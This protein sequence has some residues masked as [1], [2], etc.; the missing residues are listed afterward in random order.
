[1]NTLSAKL[2][3]PARPRPF[4]VGFGFWMALLLGMGLAQAQTLSL[5][6]ALA[7]AKDQ[8]TVASAAVELGDAKAALSRTLSDPLLTRPNKVQ[9]EQ[10]VA[11]AQA[12]YDRS[13]AQAQSSIAGAYAGVLEAE[14]QV[15]LVKKAL[16]IAERGVEVAQIRQKNGSGTA[17]DTKQAQTRL[18]DARKNLA[19]A[20]N[21]YTLAQSSLKSYVGAFDKLSPLPALPPLPSAEVV[22]TLLA[23]SPDLIQSRQRVELANLQVEL[24]DPSYAA[25]ADIDA[26]KARAEQAAAGGREVE[27]GFSLQ[28]DSL[29]QQLQTAA[30][31]LT[32]QQATLV[33]AKEQLANDKKR[34]DSGLISGLAYLQTELSALQAELGVTQAQGAYLR[35]WYS[36][37]SGGR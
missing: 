22:K 5:E 4:R 17:L 29:Y 16:E 6:S 27:R 12:N 35:A 34:L 26:A 18:D 10:R 28:Y 21:G 8:A 1:M 25:K 32:V 3:S 19:A 7:K 23:A 31:N 9:A 2:F 30:R 36:L 33:N 20:E 11:L 13:L 37:Q 15:R 24:L 14:A